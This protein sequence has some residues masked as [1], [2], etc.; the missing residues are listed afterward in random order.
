MSTGKKYPVELR[1]RAVRTVLETG[2]PIAHVA[3]DLDIGP[4]SLRSWVRQAQ[5]DTGKRPGAATSDELEELRL[6][7]S[8]N[9]ELRRTVETLKAASVYF[10]REL[11]GTPRR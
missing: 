8:E 1:E 3:K 2:R 11:D 9:R 7:R 6:L 5:A 4:E 10:A